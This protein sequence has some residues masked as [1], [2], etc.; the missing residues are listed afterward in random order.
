MCEYSKKGSEIWIEGRAE[1]NEY[2]D[3]EGTKN[4]ETVYNCSKFEFL[5]SSAPQE[6]R[7]PDNVGNTAGSDEDD[8][9]PF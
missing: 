9:I 8:P 4:K 1:N 5:G 6:E 3:K 2:V 7:V